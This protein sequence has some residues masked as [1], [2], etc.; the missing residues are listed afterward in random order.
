M[1]APRPQPSSRVPDFSE[2]RRLLEE[3]LRAGEPDAA[4]DL[5][6]DMLSRL[7]TENSQLALRL[8]S[9]L[10]QLYRRR[11]EKVSS[12]QLALVLASLSLE[13]QQA[14]TP[15]AGGEAPPETE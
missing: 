13:D 9:A 3:R 5:M 2:V 15:D 14:A 10:R 1:A 6:V 12:A 4:L 11:T 8:D 7:Q